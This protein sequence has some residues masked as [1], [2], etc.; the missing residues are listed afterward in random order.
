VLTSTFLAIAISYATTGRDP[1]GEELVKQGYTRTKVYRDEYDSLYCDIMIDK[2]PHRF[3]I[4]TG[5]SNTLLGDD[6]A[7]QH[8]I[9]YTKRTI[10]SSAFGGS[11]KTHFARIDP[12]K[13][14]GAIRL[15]CRAHVVDGFGVEYFDALRARN[16]VGILGM[17][18]LNQ[19]SAVI[20]TARGLIYTLDPWEK[21]KGLVGEWQGATTAIKGVT[22][23]A[24]SAGRIKLH[25]K[26]G[27]ARFTEGEFELEKDYD[28]N[29]VR[30]TGDRKAFNWFHGDR[31]EPWRLI[32]KLAGDEL[33]ICCPSILI[34]AF[35]SPRPTEFTSTKE[36]GQAVLTFKRIKP[37]KK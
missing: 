24:E 7:K 27:K 19:H 11:V 30:T 22:G 21:E 16:V 5:V 29:F 25:I 28:I 33:T 12:D 23:T 18:V 32:Y 35:K 9:S 14:S 17:D 34:E 3:W 37:E 6:F 13:S 2:K 31:V 15:A 1:A 26:D 10:T 20:D 36:N 4:D 8:D